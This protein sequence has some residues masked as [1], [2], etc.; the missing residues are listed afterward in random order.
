M[1]LPQG[2]PAV[3][4]PPSL[5]WRTSWM[6]RKNP[7]LSTPMQMW[8]NGGWAKGCIKTSPLLSTFDW[9]VFRMEHDFYHLRF[10]I[11][12]GWGNWGT[13][14]FQNSTTVVDFWS[15]QIY[16]VGVVVMSPKFPEVSLSMAFLGSKFM[17]ANE[18]QPKVGMYKI[19][20]DGSYRFI[21]EFFWTEIEAGKTSTISDHLQL[22]PSAGN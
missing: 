7:S 22:S 21:H 12:V 19:T 6:D 10:K 8:W 20:A 4:S 5:T 1:K 14:Q 13:S 2:G 3:I 9:S 11:F 15:T 18:A 17:K 16:G